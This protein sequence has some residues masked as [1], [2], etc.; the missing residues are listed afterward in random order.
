[1][2][3]P[4]DVW[5]IVP[6]CVVVE[7]NI[8]FVLFAREFARV[9]AGAD[10]RAHRAERIVLVADNHVFVVVRKDDGAAQCVGM[11]VFIASRLIVRQIGYL[12]SCRLG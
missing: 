7:L 9:V 5:V 6:R 10:L 4:S 1:M 12:S 3:E 11:V 2:R 8:A